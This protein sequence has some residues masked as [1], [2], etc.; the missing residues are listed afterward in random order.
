MSQRTV[1]SDLWQAIVVMPPRRRLPRSVDHAVHG[2]CRASKSLAGHQRLEEGLFLIRMLRERS[3]VGDLCHDDVA[4]SRVGNERCRRWPLGQ[5]RGVGRA[6]AIASAMGSRS[7]RGR[8]CSCNMLRGG[9][10]RDMSHA[11]RMWIH[12]ELAFSNRRDDCG[13]RYNGRSGFRGWNERS[14]RCHPRGGRTRRPRG[15]SL[16]GGGPNRLRRSSRSRG[17]HACRS[18][19][20]LGWWWHRRGLYATIRSV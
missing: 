8:F 12:V 16:R 19:R 11:D 4:V 2:S 18:G 7:P 13:W 5:R 14:L 3:G 1:A 6:T 15:R 17:R 9:R 20:A 10:R